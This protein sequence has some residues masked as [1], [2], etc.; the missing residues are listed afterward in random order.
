MSTTIKVSAEL[1]DRIT[2]DARERGV[3]AA[4][5]IEGL[6]DGYERR[7]RMEAVGHAVRG[8]DASYWD[9][10]RTWDV[11]LPDGRPDE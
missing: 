9:D 10:F 2:R 4:G 7:Q 8:A 1:R 3:T 6:L 11:T 5:L